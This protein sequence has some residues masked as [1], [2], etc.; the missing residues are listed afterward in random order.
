MKLTGKKIFITFFALFLVGLVAAWLSVVNEPS[1]RARRDV[2][3]NLKKFVRSGATA[4]H[5][6]DLAPHEWERVYPFGSGAES[7]N[8][9]KGPD[10]LGETHWGLLFVDK[11]G[12]EVYVCVARRVID[13]PPSTG[14]ACVLNEGAV[15]RITAKPD[16]P[17]RHLEIRGPTCP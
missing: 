6:K 7:G 15:A 4:A 12:G 17:G 2:E 14:P 8:T 9:W 11:S 1:N 3:R 5:M 13:G 10:C 16:A